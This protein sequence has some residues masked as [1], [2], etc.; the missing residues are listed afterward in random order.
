MGTMEYPT[1]ESIFTR[2]TIN[3]LKL[4]DEKVV[5]MVGKSKSALSFTSQESNQE[6][7]VQRKRLFKKPNQEYLPLIIDQQPSQDDEAQVR[8]FGK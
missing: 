7:T 5:T 3:R 1:Q 2:R 8:I 6:I 4:K